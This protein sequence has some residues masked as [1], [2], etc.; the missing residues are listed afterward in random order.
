MVLSDFGLY[1]ITDRRQ[2]GGRE[3][4][5]VVRRALD[6]G[7]RGVQLREKDLSGAELYRLAD[8]MRRLTAAYDARLII[9]DRPDIALAVDADGVHVGISSMPV[10]AVRRVLGPDKI[11]GYSAHSLEEAEQVQRDGADFITCG[12]VFATPSK[13]RYGAPLGVERLTVVA[14][15]LKI[16]VIALGGISLGNISETLTATV[17]GVAVISA[18]LGASDPQGAAMALLKKIEAYAQRP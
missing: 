7:V 12:P 5:D 6:G 9:N 16:P 2:A 14:A 17:Q 8:A 10:A 18:V 1:L 15:A 11:I 4:L 13:L 3:L